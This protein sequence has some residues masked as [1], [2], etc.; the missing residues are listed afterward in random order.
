M[1]ANVLFIGT[2][3]QPETEEQPSR[4]V[5]VVTEVDNAAGALR[6]EMTGRAKILCGERDL[7]ALAGR[8]LARSVKVDFWSW[9]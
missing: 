2:V 7:M 1:Q 9:W 3:V 4:T 8:R 5:R 6:P